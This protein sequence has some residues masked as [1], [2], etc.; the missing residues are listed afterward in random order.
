[1]TNAYA[2]VSEGSMMFS[3]YKNS[4]SLEA[5][6]ILSILHKINMYS[7]ITKIPNKAMTNKISTMCFLSF[8]FIYSLRFFR[9]I[10]LVLFW[11]LRRMKG[12]GRNNGRRSRNNGAF[13]AITAL[14]AIT[15]G[16]AGNNGRAG[17][18]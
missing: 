15:A 6:A 1:M 4:K 13:G 17:A 8:S 10:L 7:N 11:R 5:L 2:P 14:R 3:T 9:P 12:E 18:Q 16:G